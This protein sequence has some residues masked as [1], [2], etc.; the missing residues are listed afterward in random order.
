MPQL[1]YAL[2]RAIRPM[3]ARSLRAGFDWVFDDNSVT[4]FGE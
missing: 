3:F 2:P 1:G 4:F